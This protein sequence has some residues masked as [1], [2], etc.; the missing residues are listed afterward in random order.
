MDSRR[1]DTGLGHI[2]PGASAP[3]VAAKGLETS[4]SARA[5]VGVLAG[6]IRM[7]LSKLDIFRE[8]GADG[9]RRRFGA[10]RTESVRHSGFGCLKMTAVMRLRHRMVQNWLAIRL[11]INDDY[12]GFFC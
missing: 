11:V 2:S 1:A 6:Q 8:A 4:F 5:G 7:M 3:K 12:H 10:V 9:R